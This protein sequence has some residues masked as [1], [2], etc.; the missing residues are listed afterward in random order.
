MQVVLRPARGNWRQDALLAPKQPEFGMRHV[1][2]EVLYLPTYCCNLLLMY[3]MPLLVDRGFESGAALIL[4][5]PERQ[6]GIPH[7]L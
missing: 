5:D 6:R 2:L 1:A 4:L 7:A 3:K